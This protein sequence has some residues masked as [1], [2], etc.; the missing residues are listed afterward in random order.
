MN[1]QPLT[2]EFRFNYP[3]NI[4]RRLECVRFIGAFGSEWINRRFMAPRC[5]SGLEFKSFKIVLDVRRQL[6][7]SS[8][9]VNKHQ[10]SV[11][12]TG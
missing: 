11:S 1:T 10:A 6:S 3:L 5:P 7:Y 8:M 4:A 12:Q 2:A 9:T